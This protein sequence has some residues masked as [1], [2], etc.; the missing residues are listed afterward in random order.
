[1]PSFDASP[2][3]Y[4]VLV[5]GL[6]WL[7]TWVVI[8][9]KIQA[10]WLFLGLSFVA[11][12]LLRL[13]TIVYDQ[14]LN[15][16]ESQMIT[17]ALTLRHDPVFWR[18]V[19]GT[20]GGPI[21]TYLLTV[22]GLFGLPYDYITAHLVACGLVM[23]ILLLSYRTAR[24]W[25]GKTP[26]RWALLPFIFMLGVSQNADLL[27]YNSELVVVALL[28]G[29]GYLYA[30]VLNEPAPALWRIGLIGLLLGLV[31]F[32][33]LQ[34]LPVA[35]VV[36]IFLFIDL[37][38][39]RQLNS[40]EKTV[41]LAVLTG[42]GLATIGA[43]LGLIALNGVFDDF[44]TFYL[45][46]NIGYGD[47]P[48][49]ISQL[50][51]LPVYLSSVNELLAIVV[52]TIT[53]WLVVLVRRAMPSTG[54]AGNRFNWRIGGFL[55]LILAMSLYAVL[56]T[57]MNFVHYFFFVFNPLL[58]LLAYGW[59]TLLRDKPLNLPVLRFQAVAMGLFLGS[60]GYVTLN[61]HFQGLPINRYM[62]D[63]QGGWR[64]PL[65]PVAE[66]VL[67]YALPGEPLV[68]W[69]W[70]CSYYV[71][72]RMP[73][74]VAE[75]HSIRSALFKSMFKEYQ[76]RYFANVLQSFPPVFVDAVGK[77]NLW[78]TDRKTQG[79]EL[80]KP[81]GEFVATHYRYMGL[82]NDSRIYVRLDRINGRPVTNQSTVYA[83]RF[84]PAGNAAVSNQINHP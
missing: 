21:N 26:A 18:S 9:D 23:L 5:Y 29:A 47:S 32:S 71:E 16:D 33:K 28:S 52:L 59:R 74:G 15:P 70:R 31:P 30:R 4:W 36:G 77:Q 49:I 57:G 7:L 10:S 68:V 3:S 8:T 13:S 50:L 84:S 22:V 35:V 73:Q 41:R 40:R 48:S 38:T 11:L 69:G 53:V 42:S 45:K 58:L 51:G 76:Q 55:L 1:M 60:F 14:E 19:D 61:N 66:E 64:V 34:G 2:F 27:H 39:R 72:T 17:Q 79:H 75:N 78:M 65:S 62:S 24:Y 44:V 12:F 54:W 80:V 20:T 6:C 63:Q 43:A 25:F 37:L 67:K 82:V 56:R 81:L 46:A 83:N